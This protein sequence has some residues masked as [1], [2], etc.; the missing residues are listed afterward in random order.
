MARDIYAE[1]TDSIIKALEAGTAPW[2]RPW[3]GGGP[4]NA[5][6]GHEYRG[7]NVLL[8]SC[9]VMER[10]YADDRWL[11]FKQAQS[12]GGH[13][14]KGEKSTM[15]TFW[16][17]NKLAKKDA[18]TGEET[19]RS[20]PLLRVYHVFNVAQCDGLTLKAPEANVFDLT[21]DGA[22][23]TIA[24]S[25]AVVYHY[26][27]RAFYDPAGD[28]IVLPQVEKFQDEAGYWTTALHELTHWTG[29]AKRLNRV[30]GKRFGDDAYAA[31]ELVAEIGSAFLCARLKIAGRLQHPEYVASWLKVLKGDKRAIF[32]ASS[33]AQK[34]A[35]L[36][37][38]S[39]L[40]AEEVGAS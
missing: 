27:D 6:T 24:K 11:T 9:R 19:T 5:I 16:Q 25:G 28:R 3:A 12:N 38:G 8:L 1:V 4:R 22:R 35:D 32:T 21:H 20:V 18:E 29:H 34:A 15:V 39:E 33:A 2:V 10:G 40:A 7:L 37:A 14:R 26:G 36:L 30:F 13:V 17:F 31:E 23:D